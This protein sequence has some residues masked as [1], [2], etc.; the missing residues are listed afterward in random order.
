MQNLEHVHH[1]LVHFIVKSSNNTNCDL[2]LLSIIG[3][4]ILKFVKF[5][6]K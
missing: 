1:D 6:T 5:G 4:I 3:I 2:Q